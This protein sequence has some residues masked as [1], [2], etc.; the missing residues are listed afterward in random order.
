MKPRKWDDFAFSG[1]A[2]VDTANTS[3]FGTKA[4]PALVAAFTSTG[5]GECIAYSVD[6]GRTW[7]EYEKNPVVKHEGRDPKL[8]WH[9]PTNK[10]VMAVYD[11]KDGGKDKGVSFH[12]SP[13]LKTWS[14][15]SRIGDFYECP[16]LVELSVQGSPGE[17]R[18]VLYGADGRYLLGAFD[19][20]SFTP[21]GPKQTLWHG[22]FY[23]AQTF[24]NAPDGRCIQL[25]WARGIDTPKLSFNQRMT[26]P[27][28]LTLRRTPAGLRLVAD[29]VPEL[30]QACGP[31]VT[32]RNVV[33]GAD[34]AK[35]AD[36]PAAA[37]VRVELALGTAK[38]VRLN[39]RGVELRYDVKAGR[40]TTGKI[41]APARAEGGRLT[42]RIVT[43][44]QSVEVFTPDGTALS[45]AAP[46][47]AK[48]G[49]T[50]AADGGAATVDTLTVAAVV[51][52]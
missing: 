37:D 30:A 50:A 19:G 36:I 5:R 8:V 32:K 46:A 27:V 34:P 29:P 11:E 17:K 14:F 47:D 13:D 52:E 12:T 39:I 23:A 9:A 31:A 1:S 24:A 42:L 18:W 43:D 41:T 26:I 4:A 33:L 7:T 38:A 40:L 25:G 48:G 10:W 35:L 6:R 28:D 21:D 45:L 20:K 44:R 22:A 16:D 3:G 2:V 49:M 51:V 15:A